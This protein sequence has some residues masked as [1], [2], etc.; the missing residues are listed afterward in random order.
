LVDLT[1]SGGNFGGLVGRMISGEVNTSYSAGLVS[2][3]TDANG[4]LVGLKQSGTVTNSYWDTETSGQTVSDGGTGLT[5]AASKQQSNYTGFDFGD[6]W[7]TIDGV[8]RPMLQVF[9]YKKTGITGTEG[10]RLL[11]APSGDLSYGE[12]LDTLWTQGFSGADATNGSPNVLTWNEATRS[13]T[14]PSSA[15][16]KPVTGTGFLVYVFSDDNGPDGAAATGFPKVLTNDSTQFSGTATPSLNFTDSGTPANDGWNLMGNPYG[17]SIDWD[18]ANG[19]NRTN[20][21]GTFYVW[22]DSAGG[23]TGAYLSWNGA[24]GTL[25]NGKIAPWQGFW[26]KANASSP[27]MS[28]NDSTRST[29]GTL[30]KKNPV[31]QIDLILSGN[32]IS[33]KALVMF[34]E[35]A[36]EGKDVF[37]AYKLNSLN[38]DYLLIGTRN[39]NLESMDIQA[40]PMEGEFHELDIDMKGNNLNGEFTLGWNT[41]ALPNDWQLTL[42]DRFEDRTYPMNQNSS[43]T[44]SLSEK[45]KQSDLNV[46]ESKILKTPSSPIQ[47]LEKSKVGTTRFALKIEQ[48]A[49]V[50]YALDQDLPTEVSL[51]QNYPN[52]FNP[53]T[54]ISFALPENSKVTLEVFDVMGRKVATLLEGNQR[55]AGSHTVNFDASSLSS[56]MY[57][58]RL[59]AGNTVITRKLTL[60]K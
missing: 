42:V 44:F 12:M 2:G 14:A 19:W 38:S 30:F 43:I 28:L 40:L 47:T 59:A 26:V 51:N 34:H 48:K 27:S 57:L 53:T 49:S 18:G 15:S 13:W 58:Y 22:S 56:G 11:T 10:W 36:N 55:S 17:A 31:P 8:E 41:Q 29:G 52:P 37:D 20:V 24:T 54:T 5:T 35:L 3:G 1:S 33:N 6:T 7:M 45:S 60:I 50:N 39:R 25:E 9:G 16:E 32:S 4:G 23:G 46:S 21:D